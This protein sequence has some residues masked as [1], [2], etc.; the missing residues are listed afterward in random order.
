MSDPVQQFE[1]SVGYDYPANSDERDFPTFG[2]TRE[3]R[4]DGK[5][6]DNHTNIIEVYSSA[7]DRDFI[8]AALQRRDG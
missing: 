8:L 6:T 2:I 4:I 5:L 3:V 1:W 7:A